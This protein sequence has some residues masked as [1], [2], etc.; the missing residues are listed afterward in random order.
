MQKGFKMILTENKLRSIIRKSL[1]EF[2]LKSFSG[3]AGFKSDSSKKGKS[4]T[5]TLDGVEFES[6]HN[7]EA[8][9]RAEKE[10]SEMGGKKEGDK[11]ARSMIN[12][13]WKYLGLDPKTMEDKPWSA[14]FI[15]YVM[16]DENIKDAAHSTW[17][18][19]AEENTKKVMNNPEKFID[20]EMYVAFKFKD[21]VDSIIPGDNLWY[22][23]EDKNNPNASHSDI[24]INS[25]EAIG[26]NLSDTIEKKP[27]NPNRYELV[28]RKVKIKGK[29]K[30]SNSNS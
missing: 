14:A 1:K 17:K 30:D 27:I 21:V 20:K 22:P 16:Q 25:D 10:Y 7:Q 18:K 23:R 11:F 15:S 2:K 5:Y 8:V 13:Y 19:K 6:F 12:K 3:S 4:E 29:K 9:K 28:V 26:G 24:A